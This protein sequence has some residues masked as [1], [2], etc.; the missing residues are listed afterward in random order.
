[1]ALKLSQELDG[2]QVL[3]V[4]LLL[5]SADVV[6]SSLDVTLKSILAIEAPLVFLLE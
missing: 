1:M 3:G 6:G 2:G 4:E 5:D